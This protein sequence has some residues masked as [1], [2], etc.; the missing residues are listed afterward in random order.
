MEHHKLYGEAQS[1]MLRHWEDDEVPDPIELM[2]RFAV[3]FH[4][5]QLK[6]RKN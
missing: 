2:A 5:K 4:N 3:Y 6:A 1:Y